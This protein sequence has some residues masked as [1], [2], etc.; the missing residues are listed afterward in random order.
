MAHSSISSD[1][2]PTTPTF[3]R[4]SSSSSRPS[5]PP[6]PGEDVVERG[7]YSLSHSDHAPTFSSQED[8]DE[9]VEWVRHNVKFDE[10]EEDSPYHPITHCGSL[11]DQ[12]ACAAASS[13]YHCTWS[14]VAPTA[15]GFRPSWLGGGAGGPGTSL[16]RGWCHAND[17]ALDSLWTEWKEQMRNTNAESNELPS[18]IPVLV[19]TKPANTY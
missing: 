18:A 15:S 11:T 1:S 7:L 13:T 2:E 10:K 14:D 3:S 9:F 19:R 6:S 17:A 8:W 5:T 4:E 12:D 16:R